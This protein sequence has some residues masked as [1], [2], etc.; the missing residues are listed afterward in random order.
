M[1]DAGPALASK[2]LAHVV[3]NGSAPEVDELHL[4]PAIRAQRQSHRLLPDL[5]GQIAGGGE[6]GAP[7]LDDAADVLHRILHAF[8]HRRAHESV[9]RSARQELVNRAGPEE[10]KRPRPRPPPRPAPDRHPA[11]GHRCGSRSTLRRAPRFSRTSPAAHTFVVHC[12]GRAEEARRGPNPPASSTT[13]LAS[14]TR[15]RD[16]RPLTGVP[17]RARLRRHPGACR[18]AV[19][20]APRGHRRLSRDRQSA[21]PR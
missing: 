20:E 12:C 18:S 17:P 5:S 8:L 13:E 14:S 7:R 16:S 3:V 4:Q 15:L 19:S 6:L 21:L 2:H 11:R 1:A 9:E 10:G